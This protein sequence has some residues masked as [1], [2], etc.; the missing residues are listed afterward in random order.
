MSGL[1]PVTS[2]TGVFDIAWMTGVQQYHTKSAQV[3]PNF[4][5]FRPNFNQG[6]LNTGS[7][8]TR[9]CKVSGNAVV[10]RF[11]QSRDISPVSDQF[12]IAPTL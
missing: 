12:Y 10:F 11:S 3:G 5:S 9:T 1:D 2:M 7:L 4:G 8:N 6:L